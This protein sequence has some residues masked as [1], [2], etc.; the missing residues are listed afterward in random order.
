MTKRLNRTE[1]IAEYLGSSCED[2]REYR[3]QPSRFVKVP[4]FAIGDRYYCVTREGEKPPASYDGGANLHASD[5]GFRWT[6]EP[7]D[8]W[9]LPR[10][11]GLTIYISSGTV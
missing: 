5:A 1:V 6:P 4:V 8:T 7:S 9:P 10:Y 3:Y 11:S 2:V